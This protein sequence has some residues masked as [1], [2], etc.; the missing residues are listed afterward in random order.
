MPPGTAHTLS[1]DRAISRPF[2]WSGLLRPSSDPNPNPAPSMRTSFPV[3]LGTLLTLTAAPVLR[4][5]ELLAVDF[6]GQAFGVDVNNGQARLIGPTGAA[7]CNA[8]ALHDH[9]F[10]ATS[11]S[12]TLHQLVK[13]DRI[14]AQATVVIANLGVDIRGLCTE[15]NTDN[16]F[17]IVNGAPIDRLVRID[18]TTGTVTNIGNTGLTGIQALD[19]AGGVLALTAWDVNVGLVRIDRTTGVA[20]DVDPNLGT[21]GANIQFLG[22]QLLNGGLR[23]LGG[24]TTLYEI[25]RF[26]GVVTALGAITGSPDLRGAEHRTGTATEIGTG[27]ATAT[28]VESRLFTKSEFLA[29]STLNLASLQHAPNALGVLVVG[30]S[31]T[32]SLGTPLPIDLDPI[33]GTSG[34][35]LWVSADLLVSAQASAAGNFIVPFT[36]PVGA[37]GLAVHFQLAALEPAPG[38]WSFSNGFS[39]QTPF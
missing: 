36:M 18:L 25:D 21:Q 3:V 37:F 11:R 27:C 12:G 31:A 15:E 1:V 14:T 2:G 29:G 35:N 22:L 8:M 6:L 39:V 9:E 38:G 13:I 16:L 30:L 23:L 19:T 4:S 24:N 33:F 26:N 28:G 10:Y 20:T 17:G 32:T 5:Q 34:C 7:L